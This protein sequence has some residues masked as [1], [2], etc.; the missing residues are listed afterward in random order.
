MNI[1]MIIC[2]ENR[3]LE[4]HMINRYGSEKSKRHHEKIRGVFYF[5]N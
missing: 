3:M 4:C 5:H 2:T 1:E